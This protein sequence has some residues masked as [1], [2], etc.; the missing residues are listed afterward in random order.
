MNS[1]ASL[2]NPGGLHRGPLSGMCP[3]LLEA[4]R[5]T[6][7]TVRPGDSDISAPLS[8]ATTPSV[9]PEAIPVA[10]SRHLLGHLPWS[11]ILYLRRAPKSANSPVQLCVLAPSQAPL[12]FSSLC[13]LAAPWREEASYRPR[14]QQRR[15]AGLEGSDAV[16]RRETSALS[17]GKTATLVPVGDRGVRG[18]WGSTL[19]CP[20]G[21]PI[22]GLRVS[23]FL[24][25]PPSP[26]GPP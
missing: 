24:P 21:V 7:C 16:L 20:S 12:E 4:S 18:I 26:T 22:P 15:S 25:S 14:G 23:S 13:L 17:S 3:K 9:L 2:R 5:P 11:S 1:V 6:R 19:G 10:R 8:L